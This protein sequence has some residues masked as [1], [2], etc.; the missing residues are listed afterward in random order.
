MCNEMQILQPIEPRN[1]DF[2]LCAH[3]FRE[4]YSGD[5]LALKPFINQI[6]MVHQ[7]CQYDGHEQIFI[8]FIMA[9]VKG[10]AADI[11]PAEPNS[12]E[13]IIQN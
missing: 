7:M 13:L 11:L 6:N 1:V 10:V 12:I 4:T 8:N 9:H 5:P 3:T 2:N